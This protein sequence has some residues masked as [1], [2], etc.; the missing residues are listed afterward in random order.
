VDG[1]DAL[2]T[3]EYFEIFEII[4]K[5]ILAKTTDGRRLSALLQ[6]LEERRGNQWKKHNV[7]SGP[8][9]KQNVKEDQSKIVATKHELDS[10]MSKLLKRW[11]EGDTKQATE[12]LESLSK[13]HTPEELMGSYLKFFSEDKKDS[14][15]KRLEVFNIIFDKYFGKKNFKDAWTNSFPNVALLSSEHP[16][17]AAALAKVL[18][19]VKEKKGVKL[20]DFFIKFDLD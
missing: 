9:P 6:N 17:C 2:N 19:T 14:I 10:V 3:N 12:E 11:V 1:L 8:P 18:L 4:N 16:F 20:T 5:L 13:K 15:P 7:E